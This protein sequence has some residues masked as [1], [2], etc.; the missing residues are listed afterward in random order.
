MGRDVLVKV[1]INPPTPHPFSVTRLGMLPRKLRDQIYH[2]LLAIPPI[3]VH[4]RKVTQGIHDRTQSSYGPLEPLT[5]H[6]HLHASCLAVLRVC[7]LM[8]LQAHPVFFQ[9]QSY[10]TDNAKE[11]QQL[12]YLGVRTFLKTPFHCNWV[13]SLCVKD[14]VSWSDKKGHCLDNATLISVFHLEKWKGLRKIYFCM[15]VG[16]EMG[17]LEFL[18]LLPHM[19]RG[20]VDFLDDSKWVIRYQYFEEA[21]QLQYACFETNELLYKRG[22]NGE[23]LSDE[24][25]AAQRQILRARS[26]ALETHDGSER[27][28]EVQIGEMPDFVMRLDV[29][30]LRDQFSSLSLDQ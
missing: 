11:F 20:V 18:F 21:W 7:H 29:Q 3:H 4:Q 19:S 25:I 15:R 28:V 16:E 1:H 17:Y 14:L 30:T 6:V 26:M 8:Y 22:K 13:T 27:Y 24:A 10:Y 12:I 23:E 9:R 5:T 2:E